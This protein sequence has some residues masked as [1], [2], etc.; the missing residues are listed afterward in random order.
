MIIVIITPNHDFLEG[1]SWLTS[2][3]LLV[4]MYILIKGLGL[5]WYMYFLLINLI[6]VTC[7]MINQFWHLIKLNKKMTNDF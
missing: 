2:L 6:K 5:E 4:H 3:F 1:S 7:L